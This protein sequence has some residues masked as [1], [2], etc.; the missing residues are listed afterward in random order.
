MGGTDGD[1]RDIDP[2]NVDPGDIDPAGAMI[3][4]AFTGA[5]LALAGFGLSLVVGDAALVFVV[6]G[7][8]VVLSSPVAYLRFRELRSGE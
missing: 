4:V 2:K 7:V 1:G 5:V 3:A 8:V 6:L